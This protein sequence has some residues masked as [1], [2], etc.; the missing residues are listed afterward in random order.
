MSQIPK[1]WHPLKEVISFIYAN[2]MSRN[3]RFVLDNWDHKYINL[4]IDMR[5]GAT[6][7]MPVDKEEL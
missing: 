1:G 2:L 6:K 3:P 4:R 7:I 5:T